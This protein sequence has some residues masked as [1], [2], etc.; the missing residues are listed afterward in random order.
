MSVYSI[1]KKAGAIAWYY[2]FMYKG[3][4]YRGRGVTK[5]QAKRVEE[6]ARAAN[7]RLRER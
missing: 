5:T 6:K 4:N 3:E 1:K 7:T 2:F